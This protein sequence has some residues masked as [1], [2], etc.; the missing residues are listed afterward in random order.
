M[1][2]GVAY[3]ATL[4][5]TLLLLGDC[6]KKASDAWMFDDVGSAKKDLS[7]ATAGVHFTPSS[8]PPML[9]DLSTMN[10]R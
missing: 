3:E 1:T 5:S 6:A 7:A 2:A 10:T 9:P 8:A 4:H